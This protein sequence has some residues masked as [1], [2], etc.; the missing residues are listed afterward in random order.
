MVQWFV[1]LS[2]AMTTMGMEH[3]LL[4]EISQ[5]LQIA[6][7]KPIDLYDRPTFIR[8]RNLFTTSDYH[9]TLCV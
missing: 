3:S 4:Q 9:L 2:V 5:F 6:P 7:K 8:K 1:C